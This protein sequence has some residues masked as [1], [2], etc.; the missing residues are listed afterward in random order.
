MARLTHITFRGQED[1]AVEFRDHGYEWDT[2]AH[3]IDWWF[4]DPAMRDIEL[5]DDEFGEIMTQL[6]EIANDPHDDYYD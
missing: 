2:N 4:T 5:T 6:Y 1:V 3:E